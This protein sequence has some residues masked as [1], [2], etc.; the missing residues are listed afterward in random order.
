VRVVRSALA[1]TATGGGLSILLAR[2]LALSKVKLALAGVVL[3]T[4]VAIVVTSRHGGAEDLKN[5]VIAAA[6]TNPNADSSSPIPPPVTIPVIPSVSR[7]YAALTN[8]P[9]LHLEIV[10]AD[11]GQPI[12][13]V[14]I[15]Y[16]GW[17]DGKFMGKTTLV[18]DRFG[19]CD[20]LY[21]TNIT[22]L[23]LTTRKD[24]FADTTLL[25]RPPNGDIIPT[26]YDL[27]VDRAMPIG[28]LVVDADGN[29]VAGAKVGWNHEDDPTA[30][31]PP[32]SHDFFWIE[33]TTD[34]NGRWRINR[35]ADD[36]ISRIYGSARDTN[37]VDSGLIFAGQ[38]KTAEKQL[39]DGT[40]VFHLG[41]AVTAKGIVV[42]ANGTPVSEA[43]ILVGGYDDSGSRAGKSQSDGTFSIAGCP[44]GKQ[45]V[46]ADAPGF[47]TTTMQA[48][49]NGSAGPI[50]LTLQPGKV[51]RFHVVDKAGDP[52]PGARITYDTFAANS[53]DQPNVQ[54][55]FE[56]V[57]DGDGRAAWT[58]APDAEME[59]S[60]WASSFQ[61]ADNLPF[62]PDGEEHTIVLTRALVI[63]GIVWDGA[64][65]QR[66]PKFR[67]ALG[68][69][70]WNPI[71]NTTN[72]VWS[73]IGRFWLDF[74]GGTYSNSLEE[75]VM[76]GTENRGYILKFIAD[77]Y[78]PFVSRVI[79]PDEGNVELNVT[80]SRAVSTTVT[81]NQ[82]DGQPAANAD[83]GLVFP[84][85]RLWLI[86]GGFSRK[87]VQTGGSL[88]RTDSNG[89][90]SLQPDDAITRVIVA[91]PDGYAE[92]TPAVLSASP[93][94]QLQPWGQLQVTCTSNAVPAVGCEYLLELGGGSSD[95]V[96]FD[97]ETARLKADA[98]GQFLVSQMPPG[99]HQLIRL[100]PET[101]DGNVTSWA[102]GDKTPFE[103]RAGG[104]TTLN[105]DIL[106]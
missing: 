64:T 98:Q 63:H 43:N 80:L 106:K 9:V 92:A 7:A 66:I 13:M 100:Y 50:R 93:T 67:I 88:L 102:H 25:W 30:A 21:P 16:A 68:W 69:P 87:N 40:F 57:T 58:N 99:H 35:M 10:T 38:N 32:Q 91:S 54:T 72:A 76:S 95:T 104:T 46:S 26:N 6:P 85:A 74:S 94:I 62:R 49:L 48:E 47:A 8:G 19:N 78:A 56:A 105:L 28:G 34:Q 29:P 41:G 83:V 42:D 86:Q 82:P 75:A 77:G 97:F 101:I 27:R 37:Y 3:T 5:S 60:T 12:P 17:A 65:G 39:R 1:G 73:T 96:S 45:M 61:R 89:T 55:G 103:I 2:L 20:A 53:T 70:E 33:T 51:L 84:G 44:P 52:I 24:G 15:N 23:R 90:F 4:A 36:M 31:N 14:S 79:G 22:M 18:S 11:T 71:K 81:V 59:F